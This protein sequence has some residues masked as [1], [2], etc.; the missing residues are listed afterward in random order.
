VTLPDI[1]EHGGRM[2]SNGT[3]FLEDGTI[4]HG[5]VASAA[6]LK[7]SLGNRIFDEGRTGV[8]WQYLASQGVA[9]Q[10]DSRSRTQV[11]AKSRSTDNKLEK[12]I[13][14]PPAILPIYAP[15]SAKDSA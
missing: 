9:K 15:G 10:S 11:T 12:R 14:Y 1:V 7:S 4:S 3:A 8:A 5:R 6:T 13:E 2:Q